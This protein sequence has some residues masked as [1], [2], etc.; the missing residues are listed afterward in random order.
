MKINL[1]SD[2]L[3]RLGRSLNNTSKTI[4]A[5]PKPKKKFDIKRKSQIS[6]DGNFLN[7]YE[8]HGELQTITENKN[9]HILQK[10]KVIRGKFRYINHRLNLQCLNQL[11]ECHLF[12]KP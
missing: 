8:K 5:L 11:I 12:L 6:L 2:F 9:N 7:Y 3:S 10:E 1:T 4:A